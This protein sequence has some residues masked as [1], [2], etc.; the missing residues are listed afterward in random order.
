MKGLV[1]A[2][3]ISTA[4]TFEYGS[5]SYYGSNVNA[6]QNPPTGNTLTTVS[7]ILSGLTEGITYHFRIKAENSLGVTYGDD[8]TFELTSKLTDIEDNI[9]STFTGK[10]CPAGWHVPSDTEFTTLTNFLGG[11]SVAGGKIKEVGTD[12]W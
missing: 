1:N 2:N 12:H 10:L 11:E 3:F 7:A 4:V 8:L 5:S 9:Y 6:A